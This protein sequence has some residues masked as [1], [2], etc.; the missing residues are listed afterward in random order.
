MTIDK[1][2]RNEKSGQLSGDDLEQ[3]FRLRF[4]DGL[5]YAKIAKQL[6]VSPQTIS[7]VVKGKTFKKE[8]QALRANYEG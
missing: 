8:T 6:G 5:S 7:N 2:I 3:V 4:E 1:E